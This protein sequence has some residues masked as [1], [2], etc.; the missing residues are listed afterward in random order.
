ML[1]LPG[2]RLC[3]LPALLGSSSGVDSTACLANSGIPILL[4]GPTL[5]VQG[6]AQRHRRTRGLTA[7]LV[8][9]H[10]KVE[11][12]E[13]VVTKPVVEMEWNACLQTFEHGNSISSAAFSPDDTQVTS[14]SCDRTV[15]LWE[16]T[17]GRCIQELKNHS[18][19]V[20]SIAFSPD[21]SQLALA[22]YDGSIW[23]WE[24]AS[25]RCI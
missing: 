3:N 8:R 1:Q 22:S 18:S 10:F 4:F 7:S 15:R 25:G 16:A 13:W 24:A 2:D 9:K 23:V 14:A 21:D 6:N 17:S 20:N 19:P 5:T 11:E 12:P